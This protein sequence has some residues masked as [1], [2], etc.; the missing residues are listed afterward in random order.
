[1]AWIGQRIQAVEDLA[2]T[3]PVNDTAPQIKEQAA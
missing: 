1:M 3:L 2:K